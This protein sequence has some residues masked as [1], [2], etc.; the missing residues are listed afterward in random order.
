MARL[1]GRTAFITGS[2][3]GIGRGI[4]ERFL[5]EGAKVCVADLNTEG[6]KATASEL[7]A[8]SGGNALG[9]FC[10]CVDHCFPFG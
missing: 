8:A 7:A 3:R 5:Q 9:V 6:A 2:A 1:N 4:A 10:G